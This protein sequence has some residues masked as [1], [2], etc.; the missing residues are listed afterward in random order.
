[1]NEWKQRERRDCPLS[2]SPTIAIETFSIAL[3]AP[4]VGARET[5][6]VGTSVGVALGC[7]VGFKSF[8]NKKKRKTEWHD[9]S[10]DFEGGV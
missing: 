2:L 9:V 6:G 10:S 4:S 8:P 1:M 3:I 7:G 5:A